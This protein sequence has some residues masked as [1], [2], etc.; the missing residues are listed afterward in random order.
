[1]HYQRWQKYGDPLLT[2]TA[3]QRKPRRNRTEEEAW[4]SVMARVVKLPSGCWEYQGATGSGGYGRIRW[5][6]RTQSAPRVAYQMLVGSAPGEMNV[7]HRCDNPPCINPDHLFLGTQADNVRD[8]VA[9]GRARGRMS[10]TRVS[11]G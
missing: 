2:T 4:A 8:M 7:C 1:M 5:A 9:K 11:R 10:A 6:G 3:A